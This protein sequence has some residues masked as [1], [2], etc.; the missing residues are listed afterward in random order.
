MSHIKGNKTRKKAVSELIRVAK[1]GAPVFISVM[2]KLA[3]LAN[4]LRYWPDEIKQ[5]RHFREIWKNG[6]DNIWHGSSYCHFFMPEEFKTLVSESGLKILE[7]VGLEGLGSN[8][9]REINK[10]AKNWPKAWKNWIEAHWGLC[11]HSAVFATS[12]HML[13]VGRKK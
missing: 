4:C 3:V 1:K 10:L 13:I 9:K 6:D 2:G 5:T 11:S 12:G 7:C 8:A